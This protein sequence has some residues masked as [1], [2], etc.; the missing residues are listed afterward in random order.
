[1]KIPR[2]SLENVHVRN[3]LVDQ[4]ALI[5]VERDN[6]IYRDNGQN[7]KLIQYM[8]NYEIT[9]DITISKSAIYDC[10]FE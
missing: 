7:G 8:G 2:I 1:M 4:Q 6:I 3:M 9:G 5:Y 10:S